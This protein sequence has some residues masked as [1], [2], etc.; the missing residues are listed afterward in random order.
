M[1]VALYCLTELRL[2]EL[3]QSGQLTKCEINSSHIFN[4]FVNEFLSNCKQNK[5][6]I[7]RGIDKKERKRGLDRYPVQGD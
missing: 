3:S 6:R 5:K 4:V 1:L 2:F 7:F